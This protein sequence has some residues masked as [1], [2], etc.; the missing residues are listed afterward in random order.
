VRVPLL[1]IHGTDDEVIPYELGRKL[2]DAANEPKEFYSMPGATHNDPFLVGGEAYY[3]KIREFIQRL[4]L[5]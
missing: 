1:M 2:F 3:N 4:P 5:Q